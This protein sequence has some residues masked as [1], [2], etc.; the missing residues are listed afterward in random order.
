M[1]LRLGLAVA[2]WLWLAGWLAGS[3]ER[4]PMNFRWEIVVPGAQHVTIGYRDSAN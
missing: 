2:G 3:L 4:Y 1:R